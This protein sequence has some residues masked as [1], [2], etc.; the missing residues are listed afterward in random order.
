GFFVNTLVLRAD[1][2]GNPTFSDYLAQIKT[3]NLDAQANQ[4]V[5]FEHLVERLQPSRSTTHSPLFQIM[6]SMNINQSVALEQADL[7]LSPLYSHRKSSHKEDSKSVA[8][9][10][11]TLNAVESDSGL[12]LNFDYKV[13]LFDAKTIARLAQHLTR[14]LQG[15]VADPQTR[16]GQLPMLSEQEQQYLLH[17]LNGSHAELPQD[18][19]I[20]QLFEQQ[21]KQTPNAIALTFIDEHEQRQSQ[22]SY[23]A[24]N[25]KAN[26]LAH[27]LVSKGV[28]P[29][30]LVG[31][32]V[33]RSFDMVIGILAILKAGG[34]YVPLDPN[35]PQSRLDYLVNDSGISVLLCQKQLTTRFDNGQLSQP[36]VTLVTIWLDDPDLRQTLAGHYSRDRQCSQSHQAGNLA[37]VI[38]TSGS[39]GQPKGVMVEHGNLMAYNQSFKTQLA[40]LS[41]DNGAVGP[42]LWTASFAFDASIK[43]LLSLA[44]GKSVVIATD[45]ASKDPQAIAELIQRYQI[46]VYN[47]TPAFIGEVIEQLEQVGACRPALIVGGEQVSETVAAKIRGY[48]QHNNRKAINAYGPTETTINSTFGLVDVEQQGQLS[49]GR[50]ISNTQVYVLDSHLQPVPVGVVG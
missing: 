38:Y 40:L 3:T 45:A 29:D 5:P 18:L 47:G 17:D 41:I 21:V 14:L 34:A 39:T 7:T 20:H 49:I 30:T 25:E 48:C 44:Q 31:I 11:L 33:E 26:Q 2:S 6:F 22:L 15:I 32:C 28:K 19:C 24:L 35:Y 1:C 4:D 42:W 36:S 9:F 37:Y 43:G 16:I 8:K 46:D 27:Y 12:T 50:P 13:D 23:Q 10:E